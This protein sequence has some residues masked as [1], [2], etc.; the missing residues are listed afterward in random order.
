MRRRKMESE[1][2]RLLE[3]ID[4]QRTIEPLDRRADEAINS[5][6][7]ASAHISDWDEFRDYLERFI[8]HVEV[9][10]LG[11]KQSRRMDRN[12]TWG[13]CVQILSKIYGHNGEKAAFEIARTGNEGGLYAVLKNLA[14]KMSE[15][16]ADNEITA[17]ISNYWSSLSTDE[18]LSAGGEFLEKYGH[19]LPCELTEGSSARIRAN[20]PAVLTEYPRLLH[21]LKKAGRGYY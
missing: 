1:L 14:S 12:F 3:A 7:P 8:Q 21:H 17:R 9:Y 6:L 5:F 10:L 19:L 4:P 18:R 11:L 13:Q 20:L 15:Q 2:E 16:Y